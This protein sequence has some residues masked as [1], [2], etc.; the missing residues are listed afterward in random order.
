MLVLTTPETVI[1]TVV[2]A[3]RETYGN[4]PG[5]GSVSISTIE[6]LQVS[7]YLD[8]K[9]KLSMVERFE[10]IAKAETHKL[11]PGTYVIVYKEKSNYNSESTKSQRFVIE[12]GRTSVLTL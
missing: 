6:K 11:Q 10:L 3:M 9:G 2:P 7:I 4:V 1:D 5:F 12:E 8:T